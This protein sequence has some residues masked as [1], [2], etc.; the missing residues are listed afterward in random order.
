MK[1][2]QVPSSRRS[3]RAPGSTGPGT[4][5]VPAGAISHETGCIG[6]SMDMWEHGVISHANALAVAAGLKPGLRVKDAL[7]SVIGASEGK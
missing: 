2:R 7:L 6:D 5:G 3:I 1:I 4:R